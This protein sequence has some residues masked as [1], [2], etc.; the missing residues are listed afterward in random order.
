MAAYRPTRSERLIRVSNSG[1]AKGAVARSLLASCYALPGATHCQL[2]VAAAVVESLAA[3]LLFLFGRELGSEIE[4][5]ALVGLQPILGALVILLVSLRGRRRIG[6][7][8]AGSTRTR[9]TAG[10]SR[11]GVAAR[12]ARG[13]TGRAARAAGASGRAAAHRRSWPG[14]SGTIGA[15]AGA[16]RATSTAARRTT[17]A[18]TRGTRPT[19]RRPRRATASPSLRIAFLD[20]DRAVSK[21][22]PVHI[23][24]G[25]GG[26]IVLHVDE[27][28]TA[29]FSGVSVLRNRAAMNLSEWLER[30]PQICLRRREGQIADKE[31]LHPQEQGYGKQ[32]HSSARRRGQ[33]RR[34]GRVFIGVS[35]KKS[36]RAMGLALRR[37]NTIVG[38]RAALQRATGRS[39][40]AR[41]LIFAISPPRRSLERPFHRSKSS[42]A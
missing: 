42:V 38:R 19:A 12:G 5:A 7:E 14:E 9:R 34:A 4:M 18:R 13:A 22:T 1:N 6:A 10:A 35:S 20:D 21:G 39:T 27:A 29:A 33:V 8:T 30:L 3:I 25:F 36:R 16:H 17:G 15:R 28:E 32:P 24:D 41:W 31:S 40:R 23:G 26:R 37:P 2:F 11:T